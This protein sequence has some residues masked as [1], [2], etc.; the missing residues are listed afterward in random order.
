MDLVT[1]TVCADSVLEDDITIH[2]VELSS[3]LRSWEETHCDVVLPTVI[4]A[5]LL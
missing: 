1:N 4:H 3:E 5:R 2:L